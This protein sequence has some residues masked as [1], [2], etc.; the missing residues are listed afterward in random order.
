M[1][2]IPSENLTLES[3]ITFA[4]KR[5]DNEI[6]GHLSS[7]SLHPLAR[8]LYLTT[9]KHWFVTR[10]GFYVR[11]DPAIDE[12]TALP[13]DLKLYAITLAE[14]YTNRQ[15]LTWT[16][17]LSVTKDFFPN[18]TVV[19]QKSLSQKDN[20]KMIFLWLGIIL[21]IFLI[22]RINTFDRQTQIR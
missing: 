13:E 3:F 4:K 2:Q 7:I 11:D 22:E 14:T 1:I 6:G 17:C 18:Q 12:M 19:I 8:W 21:L 20:A 16:D 15:F 9:H 5:P 10:D